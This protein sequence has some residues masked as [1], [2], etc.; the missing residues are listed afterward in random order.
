VTDQ[1]PRILITRPEPGAAKTARALQARGFE[2]VTVPFFEIKPSASLAADLAKIAITSLE[3]V[4]LTSANA[5]RMLQR[6]APPESLAKLRGLPVFAVGEATAKAAVEAGF[7]QVSTAPPE[8]GG[9]AAAL[10]GFLDEECLNKDGLLLHCHGAH[11]AA[12]LGSLLTD[13]GLQVLGLPTYVS[14]PTANR[15]TDLIAE[16][17]AQA[18]D[19]VLHF[20]PRAARHFAEISADLES[21][22]LHVCL[23]DLVAGALQTALG[24]TAIRHLAI[25]IA[26]QPTETAMLDALFTGSE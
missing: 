8:L 20:S 22:R 21:I 23:S 19:A 26:S 14:V 18:L 15:R 2:P 25:R 16:Q 1:R 7:A 12:D 4:L 9:D 24:Q 10:A 6:A 5:P 11:R 17:N 13:A 3:A